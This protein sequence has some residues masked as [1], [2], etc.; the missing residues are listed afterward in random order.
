MATAPLAEKS[1]AC[2]IAKDL[3]RAERP[4]DHVPILAEFNWP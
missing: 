1:T 3:R 2:T 4:S